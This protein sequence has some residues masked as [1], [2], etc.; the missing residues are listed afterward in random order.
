MGRKTALATAF[1]VR[2]AIELLKA[3]QHSLDTGWVP[4]AAECGW[5][6]SRVQLVCDGV[7]RGEAF[8]LQLR[9]CRSQRQGLRISSALA[10]LAVVDPGAPAG[11]AIHVADGD[12]LAKRLAN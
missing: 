3:L 12:R 8:C 11:L 4:F 1:A 2:G 9:N 6:L 10:F 7:K 5:Y